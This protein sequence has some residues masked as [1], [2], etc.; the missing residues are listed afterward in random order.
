[1]SEN[2]ECNTLAGT[3]IADIQ[4]LLAVARE[5]QMKI[6]SAE[7]M[8]RDNVPRLTQFIL[9]DYD[10]NAHNGSNNVKV[11]VTGER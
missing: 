10:V 9:A 7:F 1:M 4:N 5:C 2:K 6:M 8:Q 11:N 3:T